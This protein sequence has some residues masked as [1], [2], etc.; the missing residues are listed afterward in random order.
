VTSN[1]LRIGVLGSG[2]GS[3]C[4]AILEACARDEIPG[5]VVVVLSDVAQ[6]LILDRARKR[7]VPTKVIGPS[8]FKTKLE[9]ELEEEVVRALREADVQLVALAGYMRVLKAPLLCAYAGRIMNV[10]PSLLPAFPGLRAWEQALQ[11]GA[12][13]TGCTVHFVEEG[14]DTG[15]IILQQP[16]PVFPNDTAESLHQRVQLTEHRLYPH[17]IRLFAEGKL[18]VVGR[19]VKILES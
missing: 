17:A 16:V 18:Q 19:T 11:Y 5:D 4:E 14:V 12:T 7:G 10:H 15:P 2:F 3:N 6:A 1:G 8:R 13:L 9:P